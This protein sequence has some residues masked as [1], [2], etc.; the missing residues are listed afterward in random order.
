MLSDDMIKRPLFLFTILFFLFISCDKND[1]IEAE[2]MKLAQGS[3]YGNMENDSIIFTIIES[4][5]EEAIFLSGTAC[6]LLVGDL[7]SPVWEENQ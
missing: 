1:I 3:W 2:A 4:N 6:L 5:F 7:P